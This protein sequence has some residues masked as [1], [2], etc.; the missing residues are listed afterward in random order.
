MVKVDRFPASKLVKLTMVKEDQQ[1]WLTIG[2]SCVVIEIVVGH[3]FY[4]LAHIKSA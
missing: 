2:R 3:Q 4:K 1:C